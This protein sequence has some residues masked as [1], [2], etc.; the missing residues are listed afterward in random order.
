M[1]FMFEDNGTTMMTNTVYPP[2][3]LR[4]IGDVIPVKD[5]PL[6]WRPEYEGCSLRVTGIFR[7][8]DADEEIVVNC[9]LEGKK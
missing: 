2:G 9:V 1:R 4:K 3:I 6:Q 7:C 5:I 8:V